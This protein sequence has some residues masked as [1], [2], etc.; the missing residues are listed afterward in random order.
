MV[1]SQQRACSTNK[2]ET[3]KE[4]RTGK[5]KLLAV[6]HCHKTGKVRKLLCMRCNHVLGASEENLEYLDKV[7]DYI[8]EHK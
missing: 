5:V 6:D 8:K 2:P 1:S 3:A 7:K 4:K